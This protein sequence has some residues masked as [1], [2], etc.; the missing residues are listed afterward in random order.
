MILSIFNRLFKSNKRI[1][2]VFFKT[3]VTFILDKKAEMAAKKV[4]YA[5]SD[6]VL[7]FF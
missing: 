2:Q 6:A 4:K 5:K 1:K 7:G 3:V